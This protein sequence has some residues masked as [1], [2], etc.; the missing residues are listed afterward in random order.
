MSPTSGE[1]TRPDQ[2][3]S[4][5]NRKLAHRNERENEG[6][7][8]RDNERDNERDNDRD[9]ERDLMEQPRCERC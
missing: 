9:N 7:N 4:D 6:D 3:K 2:I 5:C 1:C 8:D